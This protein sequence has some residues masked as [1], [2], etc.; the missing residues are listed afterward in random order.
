VNLL[1]TVSSVLLARLLVPADFGLVATATTVFG[2]LSS[3]TELSLGS[4]L[5]RHPDPRDRHFDVAWTLGLAR[6]LLLT[7]VL[8]VSAPVFVRVF[9]EPRLLS[10]MLVL[11]GGIAIGGLAN[12]KLILFQRQLVYWQ[13]FALQVTTKIVMLATTLAIAFTFG[14]Y[15]ALVAGLVGS[16]VTYVVLSYALHPYRPSLRVAGARELLDFT[17]WLSLGQA[18]NTLNWKSDPLLVGYFLG[19]TALGHY[20]F[21]DNLAQLPSREAITPIAQT[22]FPAFSRLS[23]NPV[24]IRSAYVRAQTFLFTIALPIGCGFAAVAEPTV[25]LLL[26]AKWLPSVL[27]I[28]ALAAV[29]AVQTLTNPLQALAMSLGNTRDL[30]RRDLVGF[31]IRIPLLVVGAVFGGIRGVVFARVASGLLGTVINVALVSRLTGISALRQLLNNTRPIL[32][33]ALM[34]SAVLALQNFPLLA[35]MLPANRVVA[36]AL[37][38]AS[39][40][41]VYLV[42]LYVLWRLSGR[43]SGPETEALTVVNNLRAK[44]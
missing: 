35:A 18:V 1:S 7:L 29:F 36:L 41:L 42:S 32:A 15:W 6:S 37:T 34:V 38:V 3:L 24:A 17:V 21:G 22:L 12:P 16:Q 25:S 23:S 43:P 5:V 2:I 20:T 4:A 10:I 13:D 31:A 11:A 30:F 40:A 44:R 28:Q 26:G 39:G 8:C 27:V 33:T 19:P 9:N 14:S